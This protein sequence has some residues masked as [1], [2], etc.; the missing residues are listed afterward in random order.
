[1][2]GKKTILT[3]QYPSESISETGGVS[4]VWYGVRN[5]KGNLMLD[6]GGNA[7]VEPFVNDKRETRANYIFITRKI[8]G[9]SIESKGRFIEEKTGRKFDIKI[10]DTPGEIG[11]SQEIYLR[12]II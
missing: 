1:M 4:I 11:F 7:F 8:I 3:Y 9:L 10:Q 2:V 5:I 12:E 6:M